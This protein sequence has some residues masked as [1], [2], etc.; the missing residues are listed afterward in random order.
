MYY[1][2]NMRKGGCPSC[3][4][5]NKN[6]FRSSF[7]PNLYNNRYSNNLSLNSSEDT[8][9]NSFSLNNSSLQR[10]MTPPRNYSNYRFNINNYSPINK[11]DLQRYNSPQ[12]N[13]GCRSCSMRQGNNFNNT[14][15]KRPLTG[16]YFNRNNNNSNL[17]TIDNNKNYQN[18]NYEYRN[19]YNN[20]RYQNN[21]NNNIFEDSVKQ[22]SYYSPSRNQQRNLTDI[23]SFSNINNYSPSRNINNS[24]TLDNNIK[25]QNY[26]LNYN[27]NSDKIVETM[28]NNRY[29]NFLNDRL[30]KY[31]Y[32]NI[33]INDNSRLR[34]KYYYSP[35][36]KPKLNNDNNYNKYFN[37]RYRDLLYKEEQNDNNS[38]N[39][40]ISLSLYN[41]Q[42][43]IRELL[44]NRKTF[45]ICIYG[46]PDYTGK[47]WCSDCNIAMPNIEQ[48]KNIIKD[49]Q[50]E[51]EVYFVSIPIEKRNMKYLGDDPTIQ[52]ERVP[53]LIY[54]E[55][56]F[57]KSRLIENDLFSSQIVNNFVLQAFEQYNPSRSHYLYQTRNLY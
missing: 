40:F 6:N 55:N 37:S 4:L 53:T 8:S 50:Y 2:G 20:K 52:L 43:E 48:A 32:N 31:N 22:N 17:Y 33:N 25:N 14:E 56:G 10:I 44:N 3:A 24:N 34:N 35:S 12:R 28:L 15:Y 36:I 30:N 7:S 41:Y 1:N 26:N 9:Q 23:S 29:R 46:S 19:N 54:I 45:F 13:T 18:N 21:V 27:Y 57:V 51:K 11:N 47:S 39:R 38:N 5:A 16:N 49:K 42:K